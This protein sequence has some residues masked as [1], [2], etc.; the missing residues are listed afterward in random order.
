MGKTCRFP[1]ESTRMEWRVMAP[2]VK[3]KAPAIQTPEAF[4]ER[5]RAA[6]GLM[7]IG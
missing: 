5:Y 6:A 1:P 4:R 2:T 7:L 3:T